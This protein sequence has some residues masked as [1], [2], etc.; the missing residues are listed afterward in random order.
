MDW[1]YLVALGEL[2]IVPLIVFVMKRSISKKLDDFDRKREQARL[3]QEENTSQVMAR[4]DAMTK[5]LRSLLRAELIHE[6]RKWM[7]QEHCPLEAKEYIIKT[8]EAY[9][10]LGGNDIGTSMY[11]DLMSLPAIK[12]N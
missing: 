5:G 11:N 6:H 2:L 10:N 3:E 1:Q 9:H 8:Y 4:Y 7:E 12:N